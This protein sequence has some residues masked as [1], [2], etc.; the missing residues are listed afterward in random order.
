MC[1]TGILALRHMEPTALSWDRGPGADSQASM[2]EKTDRTAA[3]PE[4]GGIAAAGLKR[5]P[6]AEQDA[7]R[8]GAEPASEPQAKPG[9]KEPA[10]SP[11]KKPAKL[12]ATAAKPAPPAIPAPEAMSQAPAATSTQGA[13]EATLFG[14]LDADSRIRQSAERSERTLWTGAAAATLVYALLIGG[15]AVNAFA[16]LSPADIAERQRRGQDAPASISVELVPDP[17]RTAKSRRWQEGTDAPGPEAPVAPPQPAQTAAL[18]QP[19]AEA[20]PNEQAKDEPRAEG[21]PMLLDIDSL[22]DA[23]AQDLKNQIDRAY[24][25]KPQKE[26]REQQAVV[27]GGNIKVRG[28]GASGKS[29][30]FTNSVIAALMKTRP[31]PFAL[32]GRVLVSFQIAE[33]GKLLYV[34]MLHSSGN[35]ALDRAAVDAIRKARFERPPPGLSPEDRTYIIDYIFG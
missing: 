21:A 12:V 23:A 18:A 3:A 25:K 34:R 7:A 8:P 15:Q 28:S 27:S 4:D 26:R 20:D 11:E 17:D 35:S 6:A 29:D 5:P 19:E 1:M 9:A 2:P 16:V 24:A 10:T 32:W 30:A 31:G 22:V 33:S 14:T 13:V